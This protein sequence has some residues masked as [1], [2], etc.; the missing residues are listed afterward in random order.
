M[1]ASSCSSNSHSLHLQAD[2]QGTVEVGN[3]H[4]SS[5][6]DRAASAS[7]RHSDNDPD[8]KIET[9]NDARCTINDEE[10]VAIFIAQQSK[11]KRDGLATRLAR[12]HGISPKAVYD[13][14][15]MR[16]RC[17]AT[18]PYW[19]PAQEQRF[20]NSRF[21]HAPKRGPVPAPQ[22]PESGP[23]TSSWKRSNLV[24]GG[25]L[26]EALDWIEQSSE[27]AK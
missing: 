8:G 4:S 11:S 26:D 6:M 3:R 5:R 1:E 19:T 17:R 25:L 12:E 21:N 13:I 24:S 22:S 2:S 16:T 10:A 23:V 14:W 15:N 27:Q 7:S 20:M 9:T 18:R